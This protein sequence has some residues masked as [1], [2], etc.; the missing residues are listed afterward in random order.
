VLSWLALLVRFDA[1]K[2]VEM[3]VLRHASPRIAWTSRCFAMSPLGPQD[4]RAP[5]SSTTP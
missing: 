3:L 5:H 1:A 4:T 2:D